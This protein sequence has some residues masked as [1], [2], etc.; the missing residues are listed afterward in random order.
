MQY[1]IVEDGRDGLWRWIVLDHGRA[2]A[3]SLDAFADAQS[4]RDDLQRL[5]D[6]GPPG[7]WDGEGPTVPARHP[8]GDEEAGQFEDV[9]L[10]RAETPVPQEG[11]AEPAPMPQIGR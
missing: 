4:C 3:R 2:V 10:K 1:R 5:F 8:A 6:A 9:G 11:E 7:E